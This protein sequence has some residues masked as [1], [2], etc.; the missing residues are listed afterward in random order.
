MSKYE[1]ERRFLSRRLTWKDNIK[2]DL[3]A[4]GCEVMFSVHVAQDRHE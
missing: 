1:G 4:V 2:M 3:P